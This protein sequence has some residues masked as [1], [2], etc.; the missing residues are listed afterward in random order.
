MDMESANGKIENRKWIDLLEENFTL[1]DMKEAIAKQYYFNTSKSL[2]WRQSSSFAISGLN[3][4][5]QHDTDGQ[6]LLAG[7]G[8]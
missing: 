5:W 8:R 2:F 3:R 1:L 7:V 4:K 6:V